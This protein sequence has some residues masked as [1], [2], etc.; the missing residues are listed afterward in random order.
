M[1]L[2]QRCREYTSDLT[3]DYMFPPGTWERNN[4][5]PSFCVTL[6][7]R[8]E[9]W[10][11]DCNYSCNIYAC[12]SLHLIIL[13]IYL[14]INF[15][16]RPGSLTEQTPLRGPEKKKEKKKTK[17]RNTNTNKNDDKKNSNENSI[18]EEIDKKSTTYTIEQAV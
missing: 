3:C 1:L 18:G 4:L 11:R 16:R 13:F 10:E 9:I 17:I 5:F 12:E 15:V 7:Q 6:V 2:V 8:N 14:F